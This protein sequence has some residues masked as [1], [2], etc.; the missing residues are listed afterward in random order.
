MAN[1]FPLKVNPSSRR[2]EEFNVGDNIDLTGNNVIADGSAGINNQYLKSDGSKVVW[3]TAGDVYLTNVQ[4]VTNKTFNS[5]II[6][7]TSNTITNIQNSSLANST[8]TING[9]PIP[10][11]GSVASADSNTTYTISAADSVTNKK[12]IRLTSGGTGAGVT[13]DVVLAG[14][15][16]VSLAR[17]GDEITISATDTNT[18]YTSGNGLALSGT[19]FSLRDNA[20]FTSNYLLKWNDSNKQLANSIISE[21]GSTI[22]IAGSLS[23]SGTTTTGSLRVNASIL[24][25]RNGISLSGNDGQFRVNRTTDGSGNTILFSSLEWYEAGPYW[26]INDGSAFSASITKRLVTDSETQTLTN[27]TFVAPVLG[28]ATATTVNKLTITAPITSATLTIADGKTLRANTGV[29]FDSQGSTTSLSNNFDVAFELTS[30]T[31]L[32]IRVR[33]S[34]GVTRSANITLAA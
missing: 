15:A 28:D 14:G 26:R 3:D 2:I 34:D 27:K 31:N 7:G 32:R 21:D 1:N 4:T 8:I 6:N 33:G 25:I 24:P 19:V 20:N 22:S 16:N 5:C 29:Y 11:G 13:D 18:T 30:D 23:L 9:I 17:S 12:I 10:L